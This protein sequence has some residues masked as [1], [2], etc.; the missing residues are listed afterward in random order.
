MTEQ[1]QH[2][3][4]VAPRLARALATAQGAPP[5]PVRLVGRSRATA[6][7]HRRCGLSLARDRQPAGGSVAVR[8]PR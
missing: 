1:Q 2:L 3:A 4:D 7:V 8:V 6:I 5:P